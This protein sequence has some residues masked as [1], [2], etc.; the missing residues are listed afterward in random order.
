MMGKRQLQK[1]QTRE[2]IILAARKVYSEYGFSAPTADI[3]NEAQI[4]HG[5]IFTHFPT[6][7]NLLV[8]LLDSFSGDM[9]RELHVLVESGGNIEKLLSM[10]IDA[11]IGHES[12]YRR[13]VMEAACLPM[14]A[15]NTFI[16]I[17]SMVSIHFLQ[18]L[19]FEM[20]AGEIK[21]IPPHMFF[22]TWIGLIHHYLLNSELFASQGSVLKE[23]KNDLIECFM[24]L[25]KK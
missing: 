24:T 7:E 5:S 3:A 25:I 15:K 6:V 13:L 8:S 18:A 21:D 11:L 20:S 2:R 12:F 17:Q 22:N 14:E 1:E 23:Y 4:S 10:H 16:I 19:E 9:N